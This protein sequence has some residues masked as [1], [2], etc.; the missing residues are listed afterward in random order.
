MTKVQLTLTDQ[1]AA[2]LR[3]YGARFGYSL[4][5]TI[6]YVISKASERILDEAAIPEYKMSKKTE[7][8]G[9]KALK[10]YKEGKVHI[11]DD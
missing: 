1:E 8:Q 11:I 4:P 6:R 9:L 2:I 3:R 5:K 10:E 7:E